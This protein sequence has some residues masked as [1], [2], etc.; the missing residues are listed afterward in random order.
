MGLTISRTNA[1]AELVSNPD[2]CISYSDIMAALG[3]RQVCFVDKPPIHGPW[4]TDMG[5]VFH[6]RTFLSNPATFA[7]LYY[8]LRFL[9]VRS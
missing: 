9:H 7:S 4:S 3:A 6:P 1:Y 5:M 8:T 2:L